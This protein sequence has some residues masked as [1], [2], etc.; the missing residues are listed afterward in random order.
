MAVE[1]AAVTSASICLESRFHAFYY[2]IMGLE[3]NCLL[4]I[5]E[6]G[7]GQFFPLFRTHGS[8]LT[9]TLFIARRSSAVFHVL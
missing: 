4:T 3:S 7:D 8:H 2:N 5:F 6:E 9:N 1:R